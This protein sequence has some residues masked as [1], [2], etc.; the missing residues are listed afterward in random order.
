MDDLIYAS[1]IQEDIGYGV[2]AKIDI[3]EYFVI[4]EYAGLIDPNYKD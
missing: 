1:Y 2:F 4:G 3:D